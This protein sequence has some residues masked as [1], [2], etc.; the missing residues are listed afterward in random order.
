MKKLI[1]MLFAAGSLALTACGPTLYS[2]NGA[3]AKLKDKGYT[4]EVFS[5]EEAKT[6]II[7][8]NYT[9]VDFANAVFA[10]KG[11]DD[12][13]DLLVA[14]FF[15][16]VND[17]ESFTSGNS[18]ENLGIMNSFADTNLGA[19]LTKKVGII[20]NVAYVGSLTSFSAAFE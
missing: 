4:V 15:T 19:N 6:K 7:G 1:M 12:D 5:Y 8:L 11:A 17:A 3:E 20:N 2:A 16:N 10:K 13:L 9:I 18:N 14:F